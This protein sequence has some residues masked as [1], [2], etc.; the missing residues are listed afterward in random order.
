MDNGCPK[1]KLLSFGEIC[2][3]CQIE[4]ADSDVCRAMNLLERLRQKKQKLEQERKEQ[5]A[6]TK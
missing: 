2:I 3:D 5:H 1:C 4:E 6:V